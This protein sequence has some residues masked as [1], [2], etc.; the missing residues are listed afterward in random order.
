MAAS[1]AGSVSFCPSGALNTKLT[2]AALAGFPPSGKRSIVRWV[3]SIAGVPEMENSE[4]IRL[5]SATEAPPAP[6]NNSTH[7]IMTFHL[8]RYD[9]HPTRSRDVATVTNYLQPDNRDDLERFLKD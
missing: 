1:F 9:Q 2:E 8:L 3:D 5:M 6:A 4:V 7:V